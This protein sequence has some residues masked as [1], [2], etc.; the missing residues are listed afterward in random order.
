[1]GIF[2]KRNDKYTKIAKNFNL[3]LYSVKL[4]VVSCN[5]KCILHEIC[6]LIGVFAIKEQN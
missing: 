2:I 4:T 5:N 3:N 1:M 6:L